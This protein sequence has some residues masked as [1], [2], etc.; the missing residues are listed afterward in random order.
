[1]RTKDEVEEAVRYLIKEV[2]DPEGLCLG[3]IRCEG[4]REFQGRIAELAS[5]VGIKVETSSPFYITQ[6]NS[7]AERG[8]G[9]TIG[10]TKSRI[11][12]APHLADRLWG[13]VAKV[14]TMS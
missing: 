9:T 3:K 6:E 1:M 8:F 7:I 2:A 13:E 4:G 10:M 11:M 12:G 14:L 5:N